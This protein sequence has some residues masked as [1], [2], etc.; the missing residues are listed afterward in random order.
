M[1]NLE[2]TFN[3]NSLR[4]K[5]LIDSDLDAFLPAWLCPGEV[6]VTGK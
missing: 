4:R 5:L 6:W 1:E 2:R 3:P